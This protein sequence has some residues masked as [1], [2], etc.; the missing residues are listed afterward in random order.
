MQ[1]IKEAKHFLEHSSFLTDFMNYVGKPVDI[2]LEKL[3]SKARDAISRSTSK[4]LQKALQWALMTIGEKAKG[5]RGRLLR[6]IHTAGA[7]VTGAVSG[8]FGMPALLV[9]IPITTMIMLRSIATTA[10][11]NGE[12]LADFH[13]SLKCIEVFTIG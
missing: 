9:E 4:A 1:F 11:Q 6:N 3:P 5:S 13:N 2:A 7:A 12:N 10:A 8:A